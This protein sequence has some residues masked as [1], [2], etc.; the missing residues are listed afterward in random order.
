MLYDRQMKSNCPK[1]CDNYMASSTDNVKLSKRTQSSIPAKTFDGRRNTV[2][3]FP[4]GWIEHGLVAFAKTAGINIDSIQIHGRP[5]SAVREL[6][7][8]SS[9]HKPWYKLYLNQ[10]PMVER[11]IRPQFRKFQF[12]KISQNAGR[13]RNKLSMKHRYNVQIW[14]KI[15]ATVW[16]PKSR[17][18]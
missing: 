17:P 13:T 3:F 4:V 15:I 8:E 1:A 18:F 2:T 11:R 9:S 6:L 16:C 10:R 12:Q 7:M 5:P 14:K